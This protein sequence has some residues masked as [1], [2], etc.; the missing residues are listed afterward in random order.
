MSNSKHCSPGFSSGL[1]DELLGLRFRTAGYQAIDRICD[2]YD[3]VQDKPVKPSVKPGY[4]R[5]ALP[6]EDLT[7]SCDRTDR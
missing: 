1:L 7:S 3:T 2:H 4:L 5:K 6:G